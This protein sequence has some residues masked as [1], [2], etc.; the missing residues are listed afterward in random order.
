VTGV[1]IIISIFLIYPKERLGLQDHPKRTSPIHTPVQHQQIDNHFTVISEISGKFVRYIHKIKN[2]KNQRK[3]KERK[4]IPINMH[5]L[6]E[7]KSLINQRENR[8]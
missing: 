3:G 6:L 7:L 1:Y 5:G 4:G 8:T 2:Q